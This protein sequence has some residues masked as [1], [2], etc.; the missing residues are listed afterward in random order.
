MAEIR[1]G[2]GMRYGPIF[3]VCAVWPVFWRLRAGQK[4]SNTCEFQYLWLVARSAES[5]APIPRMVDDN[6][7]EEAVIP[8][9]QHFLRLKVPL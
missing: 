3:G 8:A 5:V 2:G 4:S 9:S 7:R 1:H 6:I